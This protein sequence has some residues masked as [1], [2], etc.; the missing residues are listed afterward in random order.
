M[1]LLYRQRGS[2]LRFRSA[3]ETLKVVA[4]ICVNVAKINKAEA[5]AGVLANNAGFVCKM[6]TKGRSA[7]REITEQFAL[8][9]S[10]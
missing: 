1:V 10:P 7:L 6:E 5:K 2:G 4:G 9:V 3:G 8:S